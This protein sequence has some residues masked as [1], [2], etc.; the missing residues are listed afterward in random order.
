MT[1]S[2]P[3]SADELDNWT[4]VYPDHIPYGF[5]IDVTFDGNQFVAVGDRGIIV[6][7]VD[8]KK[9]QLQNSGIASR[10]FSVEYGDGVYLAGSEFGGYLRST[11]SR[12]WN[13]STL[14]PLP[15]P[16]IGGLKGCFGKDIF[17]M[18]G[19]PVY[20]S[21]DLGLTWTNT[22]GAGAD[23]A[24]YGNDLFVAVGNG[25]Y[26]SSEGANWQLR[27][28]PTGQFFDVA[29]GDSRFVAVG[30]N[31]S[32]GLIATSPNGIDW[33]TQTVAHPLYG[34]SYGNGEFVAVGGGFMSAG[35]SLTSSDGVYFDSST[36]GDNGLP[37]QVLSVV[38]GNGTFVSVGRGVIATSIDGQTWDQP[39]DFG[40]FRVQ[41][42]A[43]GCGGIVIAV[44]K[45]LRFTTNGVDYVIRDFDSRGND[46][47]QVSFNGSQ[48][49]ACGNLDPYLVSTNGVDWTEST[50]DVVG[51]F[52]GMTYGKGHWVAAG[53]PFAEGPIAFITTSE[54]AVTW[55]THYPD[56]PTITPGIMCY[57]KNVFLAVDNSGG[58]MTSTDGVGWNHQPTGFDQAIIQLRF[59][60][61]RFFA[62]GYPAPGCLVSDDGF[63][64]TQL[65]TQLNGRTILDATYGNGRYLLVT[66]HGYNTLTDLRV[67]SDALNWTDTFSNGLGLE[68][69]VYAN[70]AF[71]TFGVGM[72]IRSDL[73]N[74]P[75]FEQLTPQNGQIEFQVSGELGLVYRV[76]QSPDL[77]NWS[78]ANTFTN[79]NRTE[80]IVVPAPQG[81]GNRFWRVVSP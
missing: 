74:V 32:Q 14:S 50:N 77:Q 62:F 81:A 35:D 68:K 13:Y 26:S 59:V 64:W 78:D 79:F 46:I 76:Q 19:G 17:L 34:V 36:P 71:Y 47:T 49:V 39:V 5:F 21:V 30:A 18:L 28:P 43:A 58:L 69:V 10:L 1:A 44:G 60:G 16:G 2:S 48:F 53:R 20:R 4:F 37:S 11:D 15:H 55:T 67:S 7:S 42:A 61:D 54:D 80:S 52:Y 24:V 45:S 57:G 22:L 31:G 51:D 27:L 12:H 25:I 33:F 65:E 9:W 29:Y 75:V 3:V 40:S 66:S 56:D 73:S 8:G 23:A 70:H 6:T 63:R 72:V 38:Y 41:S